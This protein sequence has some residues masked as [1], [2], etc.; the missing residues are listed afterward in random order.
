MLRIARTKKSIFL[1]AESPDEQHFAQYQQLMKLLK[2]HLSPVTASIFAQ[3]VLQEN[4]EIIEWYS[5]L[6]G[7]P[8]ALLSLSEEEQL[9]VKKRLSERLSAVN[10]L[11]DQLAEREPDSRELQTLL[12]KAVQFPGD[13][14]VYVINEQPVIT[15]WGVPDSARKTVKAVN[16]SLPHTHKETKTINKSSSGFPRYLTYLSGFLLLL[17]LAGLLWYGFS[18]HPLNWQDYNPF[19]DEY[20]VL[21]DK[22]NAAGDDCSDL[23]H[24]YSNDPSLQKT[25]EK[26][27]LLKKQVESKL[28]ICQAYAKLKN[29]IEAVQGDCQKLVSI[30]NQNQYLQNAQKPFIELKQTLKKDVQLCAEYQQLKHKI[31]T[32]RSDCPLL[33][34]INTENVHLQHPEGMFI[35]LKQQ[36]INEINNCYANKTQEQINSAKD[37]CKLLQQIN[38]ENPYLQHP[39]GAFIQIK[40]QLADDIQNCITYQ[41]L[42]NTID[43]AQLDCQQL[44]KIAAE[45]QFLQ[46]SNNK[47]PRL[48]QQLDNYQKNC[49]R[50]QIENIVNLCPGE[51]PKKLAPELVIV[52]DASGSMAF[53]PDIYKTRQIEQKL[54]QADLGLLLSVLARGQQFAKQQRANLFRRL[55]PVS[56]SRMQ[57]AKTAVN[58]LVKKTPGDM[59]IGLVVLKDCPGA[60]KYG[61]Y[62]PSKRQQ[63]MRVINKLNPE[64][65]TPLGNAI[66]K[67]GQMIDGVNK[68]ATMIVISDGEESCNSNP[69]TI[70]RKLARQKPYLTINV[71]DI[72]GTGAGNCI[73]KAT[74]KG[75]VF[76]ANNMQ[77]I[78][79]MT[80]KAASTAIPKNCRKL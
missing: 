78:I 16:T 63:F 65:G 11:A 3:P 43:K 52:F 25:E 77:D 8:E 38:A 33:S 17:L 31:D 69:C 2:K 48:K 73:A 40:Q 30:L 59:D 35:L 44:K 26:F 21:L 56:Q 45:N 23:D 12:K 15:F 36:V 7:Q 80:E 34:K 74:K 71:V 75:K 9:K 4:S 5:E 10:K 39:Q 76:T 14:S 55:S 32:A 50:K 51:R 49:K 70:A 1:S 53:P 29:E 13:R 64:G 62:S 72:L 20:Q 66:R 27:I 37:D 18:K 57:G 19:V 24:I 61:F 22:I 47:F 58:T 68:P 28:E 60:Q 79:K 46:K 54:A 42:S 41:K 6:N 67:A